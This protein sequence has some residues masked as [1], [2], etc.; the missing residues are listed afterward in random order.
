MSRTFEPD[1]ARLSLNSA[2]LRDQWT[3]AELIEAC[4]RHDIG[5]ISPW[6]DKL[7][8]LGVARAAAMIRAH[9][10]TVTGLCRG[11]VFPAAD[12]AGRRAAIDDNRRAIDDAAAIG[13]RCLI[14]IAGGLPPGSRD[15]VG[16]RAMVRDGL[17]EIL[18]RARSA[19]VPLALEPLHPMYCADRACVN[20]LDQALDL[21]DEIDPDGRVPDRSGHAPKAA[22]GVAVDAYHVWW[23]PNHPAAIR[24]A[25][26]HRLLGFHLCDWLVPTTDLLLDRGMMGDGVIDLPALREHVYGAGYDGFDEVE[27]LSTRWWAVDGDEVVRTVKTRHLRCT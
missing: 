5:A 26:A 9:E 12:A 11:G 8:E 14:L 17:A 3:L 1:P 25:G 24:R 21:C 27:I 4:A 15:L 2:T 20:T 22:L 6:R 7:D 19:G 18:A 10:L 23:D 13:A 16:A